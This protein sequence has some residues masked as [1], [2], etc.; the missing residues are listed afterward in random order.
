MGRAPWSGPSRKLNS[1]P[2]GDTAWAMSEENVEMIRS[3]IEAWSRGDWDD[4]LKDAE[5]DF[6][7]D[8]SMNL[9]EWRGV[10][11][12]PPLREVAQTAQRPIPPEGF[13][14]PLQPTERS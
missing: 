13:A 11:R 6:A 14:A 2:A 1:P 5:P 10:H 8:N 9:G 7:L 4:A 3:A 12:G